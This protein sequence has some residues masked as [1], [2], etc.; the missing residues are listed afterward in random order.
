MAVQDQQFS[1]SLKNWSKPRTSV[2]GLSI[3]IEPSR[4]IGLS[5][6]IGLSMVVVDMFDSSVTERT[7][8]SRILK[9]AFEQQFI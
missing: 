5:I 1:A 3:V 9:Y 4:E 6:E 7:L 8:Y 2:I